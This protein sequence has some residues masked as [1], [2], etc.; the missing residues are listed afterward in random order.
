[1]TWLG[2]ACYLVGFFALLHLIDCLAARVPDRDSGDASTRTRD[3]PC[4]A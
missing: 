3:E 2:I 1:V 4:E